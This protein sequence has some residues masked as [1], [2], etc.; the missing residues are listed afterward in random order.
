MNKY[1]IF[2]GELYNVSKII[3]LIKVDGLFD[4]VVKGFWIDEGMKG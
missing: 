2:N 1:Y 4:V 3:C